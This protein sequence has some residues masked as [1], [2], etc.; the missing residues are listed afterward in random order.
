MHLLVFLHINDWVL[1][2]E[3]IDMIVS[4]E[5][6]VG[7]T[8]KGRELAEVVKSV[9]FYSPYS[10]QFP[11]APCMSAAEKEGIRQCTKYYP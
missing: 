10:D 6:P 2:S 7:D 5:L 11:N 8:E 1:T 4:S 9:M 3:K